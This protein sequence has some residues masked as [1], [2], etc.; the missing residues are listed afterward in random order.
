[1]LFRIFKT[2][3]VLGF[4]LLSFIEVKAQEEYHIKAISR[5]FDREHW[6]LNKHFKPQ[7]YKLLFFD[8]LQNNVMK[9]GKFSLG[10]N[11]LGKGLDSILLGCG[12]N[13]NYHKNIFNT[14]EISLP[15]N[16]GK[17]KRDIIAIITKKGEFNEMY[18]TSDFNV[19]VDNVVYKISIEILQFLGKSLPVLLLDDWG[20]RYDIKSNKFFIASC[21]KY[22]EYK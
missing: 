7:N 16:V 20:I 14:L 5:H 3:I 9:F 10:Y 19:M 4:T 17:Y 15:I 22:E 1:M 12:A 6:H 21:I 8:S 2:I 11:T 18:I 13:I